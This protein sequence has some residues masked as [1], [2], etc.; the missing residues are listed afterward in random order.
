[1]IKLHLLAQQFTHNIY[2]L[3]I[4]LLTNKSIADLYSILSGFRYPFKDCTFSC[5]LVRL[6]ISLVTQYYKR[7]EYMY[8][9]MCVYMYTCVCIYDVCI[10][11]HMYVYDVCMCTVLYN[12]LKIFISLYRKY[13]FCLYSHFHYLAEFI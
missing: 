13:P 12:F 5:T 11:V 7:I 8:A 10:Y 3:L 1:M 6:I 9:C 2:V 4:S